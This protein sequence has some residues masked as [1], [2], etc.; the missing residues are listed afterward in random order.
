[1]SDDGQLHECV[2]KGN[3]RTEGFRS[4]NPVAVG[5]RVEFEPQ[6]ADDEPGRIGRVHDRRNY[7]VRRSVNLSHQ[8]QIIAA[9]IDQAILM[10]TVER[11]QTS[12]GFID[13]FLVTAEAYQIKVVLLF[14]KIDDLSGPETA[15]M[16]ELSDIYTAVGYD[17]M[18]TSAVDGIGVDSLKEVLKNR[19]SLISGH[20]GVGKSTLINRI[21]PGLELRTGAVSTYH[22]KGQHTTTFAEMYD[23]PFGGQII[24]TPGIKGFGL[25]DMNRSDIADQFPEMVALSGNCRFADCLHR[26]EPGCAIK[27]AVESGDISESRFQSYLNMLDGNEDDSAYRLDIHA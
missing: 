21:A 20:S 1:M 17:V 4:T 9:N 12:P 27:K 22:N 15:R 19:V 24:D 6:I 14:N 10:I 5:D 3:L 18:H 7:M 23:L 13:R 11:P 8:M 2:V 26:A 16:L 25:V